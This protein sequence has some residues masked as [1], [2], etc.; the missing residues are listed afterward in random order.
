[1]EFEGKRY[2]AFDFAASAAVIGDA[3]F[4][5]D[6]ACEAN[7]DFEKTEGVFTRVGDVI[8][9]GF[10]K[11]QVNGAPYVEEDEDDDQGDGQGSAGQGLRPQGGGPSSVTTGTKG[12]KGTQKRTLAGI[13]AVTSGGF[14][15]FDGSNRYAGQGPS[16]S[17]LIGSIDDPY[18]VR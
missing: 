13:N 12:A 17:S 15:V 4:D 3:L 18:E 1:V 8:V 10:R 16:N 9:F 11:K 7:G 6:A 5:I 2:D 14:L